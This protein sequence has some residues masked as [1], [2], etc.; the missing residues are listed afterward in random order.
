MHLRNIN[1][2]F[3]WV[4]VCEVSFDSCSSCC[5]VCFYVCYNEVITFSETKEPL[6]TLIETLI[7]TCCYCGACP[8]MLGLLH[9]NLIVGKSCDKIFWRNNL[10]ETSFMWD[11]S[12]RCSPSW[13]K[14]YSGGELR[15]WSHQSH[16]WENRAEFNCCSVLFLHAHSPGF[17]V[18]EMVLPIIM[19]I[20]Y[21]SVD[22]KLSPT[23]RGLYTRSNWLL[24]T[25]IIS[26]EN[27]EKNLF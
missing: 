5:L 13:H 14:I 2:Q 16:I 7:S 23:A 9:L 3:F 27:C 4:M 15:R 24:I 10:K 25:N 12:P 21:I 8:S 19:I 1:R 11:Q 20:L 6:V 18:Q 22:I 26:I 17:L